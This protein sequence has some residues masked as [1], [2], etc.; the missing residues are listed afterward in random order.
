NQFLASQGYVVMSIN[1]RLGIGYGRSFRQPGQTQAQGNAEYQ[2]VLAGAKYL[3]SRADVDPNRV[4]IWGLSYGGL[5]VAQS[6]ARNSDV[7][8]AG[9]DMAGVHLYGTSLDSTNRGYQS[10]AASHVD[11][12]KSPGY[13]VDGDDDRNVGC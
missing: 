7:F 8:V 6:L 13:F 10:S 12:W 3:Q 1:Y 9:V 4:G 2:D 5:L 11:T